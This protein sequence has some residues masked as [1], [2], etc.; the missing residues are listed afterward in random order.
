MEELHCKGTPAQ[1]GRCI[2]DVLARDVDLV[3]LLDRH[4]EESYPAGAIPD[5]LE[6]WGRTAP[7]LSEDWPEIPFLI[8]RR[9]FQPLGHIVAR[10]LLDHVFV[11]ADNLQYC[12]VVND[13]EE[14]R[15]FIAEDFEPLRPIWERVKAELVRHG[16][17][18]ETKPAQADAD[19]PKIGAPKPTSKGGRPRNFDADKVNGQRVKTI[20]NS[21][22]TKLRQGLIDSFSEEELQ[23]L[24]FDMGLDYE[25]L[26]AQGKAGKAQEIVAHFKRVNDISRLVEQCRRLRPNGPWDEIPE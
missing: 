8:I 19:A 17:V 14:L 22:R 13:D 25:I 26:P 12:R 24:C 4:S 3:W 16:M 2:M 18:I 11:R 15:E 6:F 9:P 23:T 10:K 20:Q 1:V 7:E 5:N 21:L